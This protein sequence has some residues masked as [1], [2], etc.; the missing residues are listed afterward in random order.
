MYVYIYTYIYMVYTIV[1]YVAT[2]VVPQ[3]GVSDW[4]S[5]Q[6]RLYSCYWTPNF[7]TAD[8]EDFLLRLENSIRASHLPIT[9]AGDFNSKSRAWSSQREDTRGTLLANLMATFDL[10]VCNEGLTLTF[11]R[12]T[13]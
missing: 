2:R 4:L 9:L 7:T 3:N 13:S 8:F 10:S 1:I 6:V 5:F 12:G 11:E